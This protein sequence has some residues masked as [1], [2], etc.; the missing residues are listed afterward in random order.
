MVSGV[1]CCKIPVP[2]GVSFTI[3]GASVVCKG[4]LGEEAFELPLGLRC[5]SSDGCM[6]LSFDGAA[7]GVSSSLLSTCVSVLKNV[8]DGVSKGFEVTLDVRGVGYK[9]DVKDGYLFLSLGF[10]HDIAYKIP[11]SVVCSCPKPD[12]IVLKSANL[13]KLG[14]IASDI[15]K[16]RKYDPYKGKGVIIRGK[17]A[18]RKEAKKKK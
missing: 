17:F 5:E 9:A 13:P 8:I 3:Q 15:S 12:C 18:L 16:L 1:D 7:S 14:A 6:L 11:K 2:V 10:S 4:S